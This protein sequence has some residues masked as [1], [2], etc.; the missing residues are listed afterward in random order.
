M[1]YAVTEIHRRLQEEN[2]SIS[3]Q[4]LMHAG[5]AWSL[6][7]FPESQYPGIFIYKPSLSD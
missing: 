3:H 1:L 5:R 7:I 4:A 2:I 6:Y